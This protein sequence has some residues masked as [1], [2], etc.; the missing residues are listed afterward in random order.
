MR[1]GKYFLVP[2]VIT[3]IVTGA[4][5]V[6]LAWKKQRNDEKYRAAFH[7]KYRI[8]TVELPD[9]ISF[10]GEEIPLDIYYIRENLDRE[11][12]VNTYWHSA[13]ILVLKRSFRWFPVIEPILADSGIPDDFKYLALA[14]SGLTNAVSPRGAVGFW[15]FL[16]G[17]AREYGLEV[18]DEVDERYHVEKS[19]RAACSYLLESFREFERWPL[20]AASYN[21]GRKR[22][23]ESVDRQSSHDY[24]E[25]FL[26]EETSRYVFRIIAL[27]LICENPARF[28]FYLRGKDLYP[29][30]PYII[31]EIAGPVPDLVAFARE[32]GTTYKLLKDMNPWL[33]SDKLRNPGGKTYP[34]KIASG[35]ALDYDRLIRDMDDSRIY[36]DTA[37]VSNW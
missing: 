36:H 18:N 37:S 30:L 8:F 26:N 29:P 1:K 4:L 7:E 23:R 16:E 15:Q 17:T 11:L 2:A 35:F 21:A 34:L 19:T 27:K 20:V 28:G 33:R 13:T 10:A 14:E 12:L 5:L 6:T 25:L 24:F 22:I 3:L 9:Q 32:N 31:R